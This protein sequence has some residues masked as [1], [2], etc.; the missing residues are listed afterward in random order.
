MAQ[1]NDGWVD[2]SGWTDE[3]PPKGYPNPDAHSNPVSPPSV[4]RS[5]LDRFLNP[6]GHGQAGGAIGG[7]AGGIAGGRP[8]MMAGAFLGNLAGQ[9]L[10]VGDEAVDPTAMAQYRKQGR[11]PLDYK[12]APPST[13]PTDYA[14]AAMDAGAQGGMSA[15]LK[16]LG[17]GATR[18]GWPRFGAI[19]GATTPRQA[20]LDA[21][22]AAIKGVSTP[23]LETVD[24]VA[25]HG[26]TPAAKELSAILAEQ[27]RR[28]ANLAIERGIAEGNIAPIQ[29]RMQGRIPELANKTKSFVESLIQNV[30]PEKVDKA[31]ADA[32]SIAEAASSQPVMQARQGM[33]QSAVPQG[34]DAK[35]LKLATRPIAAAQARGVTSDVTQHVADAAGLRQLGGVATPDN[36]YLSRVLNRV[37]GVGTAA[38]LL[39]QGG[40][41]ASRIPQS[42]AA[43]LADR[44]GG[45]INQSVAPLISDNPLYK[46]TAASPQVIEE[47]LRRYAGR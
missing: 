28:D 37:P 11:I 25:A 17:M 45:S 43:I 14:A 27:S 42:V 35:A 41:S 47:L 15:A 20:I 36:A 39:P 21:T 13:E 9:H 19:L 26:G 34:T 22:P 23:A 8:G 10:R 3:A 6:P 40:M 7:I 31:F 44:G 38:Q 16:G 1:S 46:S 2:E 12:P 32:P 29:G 30:P 24:A 18:L 5:L 4:E 33:I